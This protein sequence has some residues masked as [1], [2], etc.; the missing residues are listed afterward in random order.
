MSRGRVFPSKCERHVL[1]APTNRG[2][3]A[4]VEPISVPTYQLEGNHAIVVSTHVSILKLQSKSDGWRQR[5]GLVGGT[6]DH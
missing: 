3:N 1:S 5:D 2:A 4:Y 6:N